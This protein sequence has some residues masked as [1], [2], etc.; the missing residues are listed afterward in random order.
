MFCLTVSSGANPIPS[1][2][3]ETT[4]PRMVTLPAV[5]WMT[6]ARIFSN[7]LFPAPLRPMMP[8]TS[9]GAT[10][11]L[12]SSTARSDRLS[13][14]GVAVRERDRNVCFSRCINAVGPSVEI[15]FFRW[16]VPRAKTFVNPRAEMRGAT[17][18]LRP[19]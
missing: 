16:L 17:L 4:R 14:G 15:P 12:T 8:S 9:P 13:F 18:M 5:G 6:R 11:K 1:S 2:S 3:I 7:V 19:R 10:S